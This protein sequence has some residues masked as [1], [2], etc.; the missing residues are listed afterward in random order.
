MAV[1]TRARL[2]QAHVRLVQPPTLSGSDGERSA[3]WTEL[4]FDLVYVVAVSRVTRIVA[5]DP[6]LHGV[7][8]S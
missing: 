8:C 2:S 1:D 5:D 4:F 6:T 7:A 3:S